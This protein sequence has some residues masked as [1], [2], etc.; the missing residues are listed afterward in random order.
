LSTQI[1]ATTD[2]P[3]DYYPLPGTG[4]RFPLSDAQLQPRLTPRPADD[5]AFLH[6][7]LQ[8]LS[9]IES[10]GYVKLLALGATPL[11]SV[12]TC[13]GGASNATWQQMRA[14]LLNVPVR[15]AAHAE[16]AVGAALLARQAGI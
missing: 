4:E 14:R 7:I 5:V 12:T 3:L 6:G 15:R 11:T 8:G 10:A 13:G 16:A 9:R 1:D 2:S